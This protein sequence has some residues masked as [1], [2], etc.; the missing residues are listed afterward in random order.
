MRAGELTTETMSAATVR[1]GW[2]DVLNR[3]FRKGTRIV[4]EKDG[5]PVAAMVSADDLEL[6]NQLDAQR[7]EALKLLEASQAAFAGQPPERVEA[8]IAKA[9]AAVR[10]ENRRRSQAQRSA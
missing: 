10:R 2:S 8:E 4:I 1:D 6:L 7:R 9:I 3:V 5:V